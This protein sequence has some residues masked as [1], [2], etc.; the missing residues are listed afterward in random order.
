MNVEQ[1]RKEHPKC[2]YCEHYN[3]FVLGY[4]KAKERLSPIFLE[5][6]FAYN[7]PL[8]TPQKYKNFFDELNR[9]N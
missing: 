8:Y 4:C 5:K 2:G 3:W 6:F 9:K 1:Y 7:C